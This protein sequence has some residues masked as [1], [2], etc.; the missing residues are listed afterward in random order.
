M[1]GAGVQTIDDIFSQL[2]QQTVGNTPLAPFAP[3]LQNFAYQMTGLQTGNQREAILD[4]VLFSNMTPY[5]TS[6]EL[7]KRRMNRV[8]G[9][10]LKLQSMQARQHFFEDV[11]TTLG[12]SRS[13]E[14]IRNEALGYMSNPLWS[15]MY[16]MLDPDGINAAS[17]HLQTAGAN[18]IRRSRNLGQRDAFLRARA[19]G[20][21]F[22][23]GENGT[24]QYKPSDYGFMDVGETSAVIAALTR[25]ID[26]YQGLE[27]MNGPDRIKAASDKIRKMAQ[28]YTKALSPLKDVFGKD[29]PAMIQAVEDLAGQKFTQMEATRIGD[30]AQRVIA[31][32][33]VGNYTIGQLSAA[34][35][36]FSTAI[37]GM[38]V[39]YVNDLGSLA[40]SETMLAITES[41]LAPT[42]MSR[43]RFQA[44]MQDFVLRS[45]NSRG[46]EA[47]NLAYALWRQNNPEGD[48]EQFRTRYNE[49]RKTLTTDKAIEVL[50]GARN[51]TMLEL[52]KGF[53]AFTEAVEANLGGRIA[54]MDENVQR[55]SNQGILR[56]I[57]ETREKTLARRQAYRSVIDMAM[58]D[59]SIL[60]DDTALTNN[61]AF[62]ALSDAQQSLVRQE[63]NMIKAG[64]RGDKLYDALLAR[65][66]FAKFAPAREAQRQKMAAA[67]R[68]KT[69]LSS[70]LKGAIRAFIGGDASWNTY[71]DINGQLQ[72]LDKRDQELAQNAMRRA[73]HAWAL[74]SEDG[75]RLSDTFTEDFVSYEFNNGVTNEIYNS[76][77]EQYEKTGDAGLLGAMIAT[78]ELDETALKEYLG[79]KI[80]DQN[81]EEWGTLK[82]IM[83][84]GIAG[85]RTKLSME[86]RRT[87]AADLMHAAA[88]KKRIGSMSLSKNAETKRDS[89][90]QAIEGQWG[91]KGFMD[92][93]MVKKIFADHGLSSKEFEKDL[94]NLNNIVNEVYGSPGSQETQITQLLTKMGSLITAIESLVQQGTNGSAGDSSATPQDPKPNK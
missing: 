27:N 47:L 32:A 31:G 17:Q 69:W 62:K 46:A 18:I 21:L 40:Q 13:Q 61:E 1:Q 37:R 41:G 51:K 67:S 63:I 48:M 29:V 38:N 68:M 14:D 73:A 39:P 53:T 75:T 4:T 84:A 7:Q 19:I 78:R 52:G 57:D 50:S 33:T 28:D 83:V 8:A 71:K 56:I 60:N 25:D 70:D 45:S 90:I 43:G 82:K 12:P 44:R 34:N 54:S 26:P 36:A 80:N 86:D 72:V 66:N 91:Q 76:L 5:G 42:T 3:M 22:M 88:L 2:L 93:D 15:T 49:L 35:T 24:Y 65:D 89:I 58:E 20:N 74:L 64:A 11:I 10:A 79:D 92:A 59:A 30:I 16:N 85:D 9:D 6:V 87:E 81:S 77:T 94:N 23:T 55:L